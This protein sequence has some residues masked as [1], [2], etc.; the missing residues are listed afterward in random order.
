MNASP[1]F[2]DSLP[3]EAS[4]VPL[5][6]PVPP[7]MGP[8]ALSVAVRQRLQPPEL[9]QHALGRL[10][11]LASQLARIDLGR[12]AHQLDPALAQPQLIVFAGDH[13]LAD[14]KVTR[15]PQ[16]ATRDRVR[17][18]LQGKAWVNRL[19][20]LHGFALTVVDAGV[21]SHVLMPEDPRPV[22]PF[23]VR[24]IAYGTRNMVLS[25]AMS[26]AQMHAAIKAGMDV[27]RH[28]PGTVLALGDVGVASTSCAALMLSRLCGVPLAD[29][30]G[31]GSGLDDDELQ[32]KVEILVNAAARHRRAVHALD[33]LATMGGFEI[34]M[35]VGAMLQAASEQRV[36]LIDGFVSGAAALVTRSL[37]PAAMD[38]LVF[39]HRSSEPGHRLL[40]IHLQSPP[41]IDLELRMGQGVGT[42]LA[43]PMLLAAQRLLVEPEPIADAAGPD[44][45]PGETPD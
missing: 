19:A 6:P 42:L 29:A 22:V 44:S 23:L 24:K 16:S 25:P 30:C 26:Q 27:V 33:V 36:V 35:M 13:G 7:L 34:A 3:L 18:I 5:L 45:T 4:V 14:E 31:R 9:A 12:R 2:Q 10:E 15:F 43:W 39:C 41:L 28:T 11:A 1:S 32:L 40:L 38:Y 8:D 17:Q 20:E 37:C 21:A